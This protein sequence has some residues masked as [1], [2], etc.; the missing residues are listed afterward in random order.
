MQGRWCEG[1]DRA[2]GTTICTVPVDVEALK[3]QAALEQKALDDENLKA[4]LDDHVKKGFRGAE[5][6]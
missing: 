2:L 6:S 5:I 3:K 4:L 1:I